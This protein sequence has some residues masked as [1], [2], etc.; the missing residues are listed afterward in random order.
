[1]AE[2]IDGEPMANPSK[3][4]M[5]RWLL[6]FHKDNIYRA[7]KGRKLRVVQSYSTRYTLEDHVQN[8]LRRSLPH[9][10]AIFKKRKNLKTGE[11]RFVNSMKRTA[12]N[13][14]VIHAL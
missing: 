14:M 12:A 10:Y 6:A 5:M 8:H 4:E 7:R 1:M 2:E 11:G 9:S 13:R 3:Q